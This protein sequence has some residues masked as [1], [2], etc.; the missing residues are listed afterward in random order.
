[1]WKQG[2]STS[3][4]L[5]SMPESVR[6]EMSEMLVVFT[7]TQQIHNE[8]IPAISPVA[9]AEGRRD[10]LAVAA[11]MRENAVSSGAGAKE[12]TRHDSGQS[13]GM[14]AGLWISLQDFFR[15]PMGLSPVS[16]AVSIALIS[17]AVVI[18]DARS[19]LPGDLTYPLKEWVRYQQYEMA[20]E[21]RKDDVLDRQEEAISEEIMLAAARGEDNNTAVIEGS[22]VLRLVSIGPGR[23]Q[24]GEILVAPRYQDDANLEVYSPMEIEGDL[25]EGAVVLLTYKIL[26]GQTGGE[27]PALVQGVSM[28]VLD[29]PAAKPELDDPAVVGGSEVTDNEIVDDPAVADATVEED[30][31][32]PNIAERSRRTPEPSAASPQRA[33]STTS[34]GPDIAGRGCN[35]APPTWAIKQIARNDT[36]SEIAANTGTTVSEL[37]V[38][39]CLSNSKIIAGDPIRIPVAMGAMPSQPAR[40]PSAP[41]G[42]GPNAGTT[43]GPQ[44]RPAI[45]PTKVEAETAD[46]QG[47]PS[48]KSNATTDQNSLLEPNTEEGASSDASAGTQ[49][50]QPDDAALPA[51]QILGEE[52][53]PDGEQ[54]E[55]ISSESS[56]GSESSRTTNRGDGEALETTGEEV[57]TG[58]EV[59]TGEEVTDGEGETA[60]ENEAATESVLPDGETDEE[61]A[62]ATS[63]TRTS[64]YSSYRAQQEARNAATIDG[65]VTTPPT[66]NAATG[67]GSSDEASGESEGPGSEAGASSGESGSGAQTGQPATPADSTSE[68]AKPAE[69]VGST[70]SAEE[71]ENPAESAGETSSSEQP[72]EPNP[73]TS[74][75]IEGKESETSSQKPEGGSTE[76]SEQE[77]PPIATSGA[78]SGSSTP[79]TS[80][81]EP[82]DSTGS[83]STSQSGASGFRRIRSNR[84]TS[85]TAVD[86][87]RSRRVRSH[88]RHRIVGRP[89]FVLIRSE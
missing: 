37:M 76:S 81:A 61:V 31:T 6:A 5:K 36:L 17:S 74:A 80:N 57:S 23:F 10:F 42:S 87:V 11:S 73:S 77:S 84:T 14:L 88:G 89:R 38:A 24:V 49:E 68:P 22:A 58:D 59:S 63:P 34:R 20:R 62:P 15:T 35:N 41:G 39:N 21:E 44:R 53:G 51:S 55:K 3:D 19:A 16:L 75:T 8:P 30:A 7:V 47:G 50:Q 72:G 70:G 83:S 46:D 78:N 54:T 85:C 33:P 12:E 13:L 60:G 25:Q 28:K 82:S 29:A 71:E 48:A 52:S 9:R 32:T 69:S 40:Q 67:T 2:E 86:I 18:N 79:G 56:D 43:G 4:V 27:P 64:R 66:E 65:T 26:P 45:A 1:M